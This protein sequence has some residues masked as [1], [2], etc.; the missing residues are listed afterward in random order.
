LRPNTDETIARVRRNWTNEEDSTLED[1]IEKHNDKDW[2][3]ISALVLDRTKTQLCMSRWYGF[4]DSKS[5]ATITRVGKRTIDEDSTQKDA[6]VKHNGKHNGKKWQDIS[7][8]VPGRSK[9]QCTSRWHAA[10]DSKS[11]ETTAREG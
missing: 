3:A 4:L 7:A 10:L 1:A 8:L 6:V 11:D 5:D 2:A 9:K